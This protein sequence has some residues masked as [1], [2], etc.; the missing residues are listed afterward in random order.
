MAADKP[1]HQSLTEIAEQK[2]KELFTM[3][4]YQTQ[5]GELEYNTALQPG[6]PGAGGEYSAENPDAVS[7]GDSKGKGY[8][9]TDIGKDQPNKV[10]NSDDI[11]ERKKEIVK[12]V[13]TTAN[14]YPNFE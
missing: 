5:N 3:N 10:G 8:L 12:N 6:T 14:E 4:N 1:A 9:G 2:R 13:Y 7:D 11:V